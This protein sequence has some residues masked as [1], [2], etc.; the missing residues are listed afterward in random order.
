MQ[1]LSVPHAYNREWGNAM[2]RTLTKRFRDLPRDRWGTPET[3][4]ALEQWDALSAP[5]LDS[6]SALGLTASFYWHAKAQYVPSTRWM[7]EW[8][9]ESYGKLVGFDAQGLIN[10]LYGHALLGTRPPHDWLTQ[11]QR[12][13]ESRHAQLPDRELS[14]GLYALSVMYLLKADVGHTAKMLAEELRLRFAA[15]D[16]A[17]PIQDAHQFYLAS[18]VFGWKEDSRLVQAV[19]GGDVAQGE[20]A[21]EGRIGRMLGNACKRQRAV[22]GWK[23][24]NVEKEALHPLTLSPSDFRLTLASTKSGSICEMYLE[25]DGNT[26]FVQHPSGVMRHNG[27][28]VLRDHLM[29]RWARQTGGGFGSIPMQKAD[30][31]ML[32]RELE[33]AISGAMERVPQRVVTSVAR[34]PGK[35]DIRR[36]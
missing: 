26:H 31:D 10:S 21:T 5:H 19:W 29:Q 30:G 4:Q 15:R 35:E 20:S 24:L 23:V 7:Q 8:Y 33:S 32:W 28:T 11:W 25:V 12:T 34:V 13:V 36:R 3:K 17:I 16:Y 27:K 14:L 18:S 2:S 1:R 9:K 6:F 22:A